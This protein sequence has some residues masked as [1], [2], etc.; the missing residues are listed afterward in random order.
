MIEMFEKCR[1][2]SLLDFKLIVLGFEQLDGDV[3]AG[4]ELV[5][6]PVAVD[7]VALAKVVSVLLFTHRWGV[8]P[9]GGCEVESLANSNGFGCLG[10]ACHFNAMVWAQVPVEG[11]EVMF[12]RVRSGF[13]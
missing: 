13:P 12:D 9:M 11:V 2:H 6:V 10:G 4:F 3:N 7:V 8:E 5:V 1:V